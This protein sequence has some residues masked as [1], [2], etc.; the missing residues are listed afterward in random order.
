MW[1]RTARRIV[2]RPWFALIAGTAILLAFASPFLSIDFGMPSDESLP[3]GLSQREAYEELA[4]GFGPGINAP[5]IVAVGVEN[6]IS[7][8]KFLVETAEISKAV[9]AEESSNTV[10]GVDFAVGPIP[11]SI[12][13][14]RI[15]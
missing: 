14:F 8:E 6:P 3:D 11:N 1:E 9:G 5:L 7:L 12:S 15:R 10:K 2:R 4:T 13:Y